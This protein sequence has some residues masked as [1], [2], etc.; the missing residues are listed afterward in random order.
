V[1][2]QRCAHCGEVIGVYEPIRVLCADGTS[3]RGSLLTLGDREREPGSALVHE[4]CWEAF[5]HTP[6]AQRAKASG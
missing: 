2:R 6:A 4:R 5:E 1:E 3:V